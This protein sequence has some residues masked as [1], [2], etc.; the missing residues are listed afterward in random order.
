MVV[1]CNFG[2]LRRSA[3]GIISLHVLGADLYKIAY[4]IGSQFH[5]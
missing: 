3:P 2:L 1:T 4:A 5:K